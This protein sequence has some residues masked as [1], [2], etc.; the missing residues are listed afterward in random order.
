V[1]PYHHGGVR[2]AHVLM[3][4]AVVDFLDLSLG[5]AGELGLELQQLV[6]PPAATLAG[7][8][9]AEGELRRRWGVGVVAVQRGEKLFPNPEADLRLEAGDVLVVLGTRKALDDFAGMAASAAE[10]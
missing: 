9:L 10:V 7:R 6:L 4:P 5:P 2:L 8:T 3:K 1:R